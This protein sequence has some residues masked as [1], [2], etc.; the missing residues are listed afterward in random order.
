MLT[1]RKIFT[2]F[3]VIFAAAL[4]LPVFGQETALET[5]DIGITVTPFQA[6]KADGPD[7][8][9]TIDAGTGVAGDL[10]VVTPNVLNEPTYLQY[11]S[12][13]AIGQT[14]K[15]EVAADAVLPLGLKL[16]IRA[17]TPTGHGGVG[18]PVAGGVV[19][20]NGY[21]LGDPLKIID[22]IKSCAT[23][24]EITQGPA[25]HYTVSIDEATFESLDSTGAAGV[26]IS[27]TILAN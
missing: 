19:M 3:V 25:I 21:G 18:T 2:T 13:V 15:I 17:G 23:G 5:V 24:S 20:D 7:L 4:V 16:N 6:I 26:T 1:R 10:P 9:F 22:D 27:F 8:T 11:T 12:V 14:R